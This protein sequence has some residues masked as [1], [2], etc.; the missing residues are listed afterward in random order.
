LPL[1][2]DLAVEAKAFEKHQ[3]LTD[4][5]ENAEAYF[6]S[7]GKQLISNRNATGAAATRFTR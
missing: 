3:T 5:G 2:D 4:G 7:D 6:F 1:K